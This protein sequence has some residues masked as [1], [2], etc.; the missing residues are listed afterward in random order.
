M[1]FSMSRYAWL[2]DRLKE[3]GRPFGTFPPRHPA[4]LLLRSDID[5]D[6]VFAV[7][8]ARENAARDISATFFVLVSG[9]FY[10]IFEP[11]TA[12]AIRQLV[13]LGQRVGLHYHHT[14]D[15]LDAERLNREFDALRMIAPQAQRVVAWHNP[16]GDL[17]ALNDA[18]A[19]EG[20]TSAY[21]A[22]IFGPGRY[23]SDSNCARDAEFMADAVARSDAETVQVLCHPLL[24]V[25]GGDT[26]QE[27]LERY[28]SRAAERL[29]ATLSEQNSVWRARS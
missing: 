6:P 4:G 10:S 12:A 29:D 24:W 20:F 11:A 7:E 1:L 27:V 23:T 26:M 19:G 5:Y 3:T 13:A 15:R 18:L 9:P 8:L 2:L 22:A 21:D 28:V 16:E 14:D 25:L 17:D